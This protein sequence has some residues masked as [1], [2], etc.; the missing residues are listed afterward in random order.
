[1]ATS[2]P[3]SPQ[4]MPTPFL[5]L[6]PALLPAAEAGRW[7]L[8]WQQRLRGDAATFLPCRRPRRAFPRREQ[9]H[10]RGRLGTAAS[11]SSRDA[12]R[13]RRVS[14]C[15]RVRRSGHSTFPGVV[16][17]AAAGRQ[18]PEVYDLCHT[19]LHVARV[20]NTRPCENRTRFSH[21]R[22]FSDSRNLNVQKRAT[23]SDTSGHCL[24]ATA[25]PSSLRAAQPQASKSLSAPALTV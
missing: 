16:A 20:R 9:Y 25:L 23:K 3:T 5:E 12:G 7:K 21:G 14:C 17:C 6:T 18:W 8:L 4:T 1:M 13:G 24:P 15:G 22:V 2:F 10:G 19:F 11:V